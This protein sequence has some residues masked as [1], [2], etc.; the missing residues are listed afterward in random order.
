M[1]PESALLICP[2]VTPL[3]CLRPSLRGPQRV[4]FSFLPL[5]LIITCWV[6]VS[7]LIVLPHISAHP[8]LSFIQGCMLQAPMKVLPH[9]IQV[10]MVE[11]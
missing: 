9:P 11:I 7:I 1:R 3:L 4:L 10:A 6:H 2:P 5:H 8:G